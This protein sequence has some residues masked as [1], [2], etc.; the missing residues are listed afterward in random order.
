MVVFCS[1]YARR[2]QYIYDGNRR[3]SVEKSPC[4]ANVTFAK[5]ALH[6]ATT[7]QFVNFAIND[8]MAVEFREWLKDTYV[9]DEIFF[10][11]LNVSPQLGVPGAYTGK[12]QT[13][14]S[15]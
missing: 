1:K 14:V 6:V 9:P 11:S 4:P 15:C 10:S 5:G 12:Y 13:D 7:R 8:K 3:T 2:Y